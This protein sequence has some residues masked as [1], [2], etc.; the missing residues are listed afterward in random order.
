MPAPASHPISL[1]VPRTQNTAL[2]IEFRC[3]YTHD[4][5]RKSKRWQDG[6]LRF[7]TFNKRAMVYDLPRNFVGDCHWRKTDDVVEGDELELE[8]AG[9]MVDVG[10]EV[11]RTTNDLTELLE[12]RKPP[13]PRGDGD[14]AAAALAGNQLKTPRRLLHASTTPLR[15][16]GSPTQRLPRG[17]G[18]LPRHSPLSARLPGVVGSLPD[19]SPPSVLGNRS[20][21]K[22]VGQGG[23]ATN[24]KKPMTVTR[25]AT[26]K[27]KINEE[28][29]ASSL[30]GR[31]PPRVHGPVAADA[32]TRKRPR[33]VEPSASTR[34]GQNA[35]IVE[36]SDASP[37]AETASALPSN[38][39]PQNSKSRRALQ[40]P[41]HGSPP[42]ASLAAPNDDDALLHYPPPPARTQRQ[43]LRDAAA[44]ELRLPAPS[45][46][47][48]KKLLCQ[49]ASFARSTAAATSPPPLRFP[50]VRLSSRSPSPGVAQRGA[51]GHAPRK[52]TTAGRLGRRA[53]YEEEDDDGEEMAS[54]PAAPP[55]G[56]SHQESLPLQ[57]RNQAPNGPGRPAHHQR[58]TTTGMRTAL[59][60][61]TTQQQQKATSDGGGGGGGGGGGT[62]VRQPQKKKQQQQKQ[63]QQQNQTKKKYTKK[64]T[65]T[66]GAA[67]AAAPAAA[68]IISAGPTTTTTTTTKAPPPPG[69]SPLLVHPLL[70]VVDPWSVEA[71]D[72]FDWKPPAAATTVSPPAAAAAAAEG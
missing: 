64:K 17:V 7:H 56:D 40:A 69:E 6:F 37:D 63:Q 19:K 36:V 51:C 29:H 34:I 59:K 5:R 52:R 38:E 2:V 71:G 55:Q 35:E 48:R 49:D 67:E 66:T 70:D 68:R 72:L 44:S 28:E 45:T 65:T 20:V 47:R 58:P 30:A 27:R 3:L 12:K 42:P 60:K 14:H 61:G 23:G 9:V 24:G 57:H 62:A 26:R 15:P 39:R 33:Q 10:E 1:H 50:P 43:P 21:N 25:P 54:V 31:P 4:L 22:L 16:A 11:G 41:S 18:S 53:E 8:S 46:T 13:P 32:A